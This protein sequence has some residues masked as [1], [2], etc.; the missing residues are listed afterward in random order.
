[1][2]CF[3]QQILDPKHGPCIQALSLPSSALDHLSLATLDLSSIPANS[4]ARYEIH[5]H[6]SIALLL[7][8]RCLPSVA[9]LN[10][11]YCRLS[12]E[13]LTGLLRSLGKPEC[14]VQALQLARADLTAIPAGVLERWL[15]APVC[16]TGALSV[17]IMNCWEITA[18][19]HCLLFHSDRRHVE[20]D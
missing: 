17:I 10:L 4:L 1:M 6:Y 16:S 8:T 7:L 2:F 13:Q 11:S 19:L 15:Q 18:Y 9:S 20:C 12:T 5:T 3:A 14:L